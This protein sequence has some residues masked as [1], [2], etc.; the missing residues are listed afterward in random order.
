MITRI[1]VERAHLASARI[2]TL[3][4]PALAEGQVLAHV[5]SFALTANNVTYGVAGDS[6]GYWKFFP[7]EDEWGV[8]PVWGFAT[9]TH[10]RHA[11]VQEG[12]RFWG[13]LPMASHL[14]LSPDKVG[15]SGFVDAA[16]HRAGLPEVYNRYSFTAGDSPELAALEA[17]RCALFPLF[18]TAFLICDFLADNAWFG[19]R[20]V[21]ILS[22]SSKT[23]LGLANLLAHADG[24]PVRVVGVTSPANLGFV[25]GLGSCDQVIVY[26]EIAGLDPSVPT[27][28]VDMAGSAAALRAI[29]TLFGA[30]L[31]HSCQVGMT[32]WREGGPAADLPGPP[33]TLF[34]APSQIVKREADWGP[35]VLGRRTA[36]EQ[37]RIAREIAGRVGVE[38]VTDAE[39]CRDVLADLVAGRVTPDRILMLTVA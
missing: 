7:A 35:G 27:I 5:D 4:E 39:P 20:Q 23:G 30:N 3:G 32:H 19:A 29:H 13:F 1:E 12:A 16:A 36:V 15:R 25:E 24:R 11:E 34:F 9:V 18:N 21:V 26:D 6:F 22:A 8:I 37:V 14:V 28:V 2:T 10:S 17:E 31:V 38:R 33:P